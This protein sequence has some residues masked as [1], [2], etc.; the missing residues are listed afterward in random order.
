MS[1]KK[2]TGKLAERH[3]SRRIGP[4]ASQE[5]MREKFSEW[6]NEDWET[7]LLLCEK[8]GV[9]TDDQM[10]MKLA[11]ALARDFVPGFQPKNQPGKKTKWTDWHKSILV[12]ELERVVSDRDCS[13]EHA[14]EVLSTSEPWY[15][16]LEARD[17]FDP[18]PNRSETLRKIYGRFKDTPWARV[19]RDAFS[20]SLE[21]R[22]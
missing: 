21:T 16:F 3:G 1:K 19:Y 9:S 5:Y 7:I 8:Y 11:I 4:L 10:W 14:A 13:I 20:Y 15:G 6:S 12:I 17:K 18:V 22:F 2:F